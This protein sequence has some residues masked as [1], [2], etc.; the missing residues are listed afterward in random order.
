MLILVPQARWVEDSA[1]A[2]ANQRSA[3]NPSAAI[4]DSHTAYSPR[5]WYVP[6]GGHAV[7]FRHGIPLASCLFPVCMKSDVFKLMLEEY[8]FNS[9]RNSLRDNLTWCFALLPS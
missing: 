2:L 3:G 6:C 4:R 7:A 5:P 8:D 9:S 1:R